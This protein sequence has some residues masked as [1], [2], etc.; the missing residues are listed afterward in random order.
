MRV[1][2]MFFA[3]MYLSNELTCIMNKVGMLF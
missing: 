3:L 2:N 1:K